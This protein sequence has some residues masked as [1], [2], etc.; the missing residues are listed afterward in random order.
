[1]GKTKKLAKLNQSKCFSNLINVAV[2]SEEYLTNVKS[3]L[4]AIGGHKSVLIN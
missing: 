1:L 3:A 2:G 4:G